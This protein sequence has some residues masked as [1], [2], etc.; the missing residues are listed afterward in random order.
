[1]K[2]GM[3]IYR[4]CIVLTALVL[5]VT[6]TTTGLAQEVS[7]P[8][9]FAAVIQDRADGRGASR[10]QPT[11]EQPKKVAL[12]VGVD[13]YK[14]NLSDLNFAEADVVAVGNELENL[15]FRVQYLTGTKATKQNIE[16]TINALIR[17]LGK[18]DIFLVML[19]GHGQQLR[20]TD[21]DTGRTRDENYF[22]P[23]DAVANSPDDLYSL[24]F[25]VDK[26][27]KENVGTRLVIVDAC[28]NIA[29]ITRGVQGRMITLP[30]DTAI[31]FSCRAGQVSYELRRLKH[32]L[33]THALL[34][35]LRGGAVRNEQISWSQIIAYVDWLMASPEI[36]ELMPPGSAQIPISASNIPQVVLADGMT[37]EP[38]PDQPEGKPAKGPV[39]TNFV[40]NSIGMRLVRVPAG[41][42][43]MGSPL[44]EVDR[45]ADE[46]QH[47]VS[48]EEPFLMGVFEVTQAEFLEVMQTNANPSYFRLRGVGAKAVKRE[49]TDQL[50]VEQVS[51]ADADKFCRLLSEREAEKLAG[52]RYR[53]PREA[54]W[55]YACRAGTSTPFHFGA[56]FTKTQ[57]NADL[58]GGTAFLGHTVDV[59]SYLPNG[60]GLFNMHGNVSEWCD[61]FYAPDFYAQSASVNPVGPPTGEQRVI[62]GG[63]WYDIPMMLRS[64]D[65][66]QADPNSRQPFIGFRVVCDEVKK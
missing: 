3:A 42:F 49:V 40:T 59:A 11:S 8:K 65:R 63:S 15:G 64:A 24:S 47:S 22:C 53:L 38:E 21:R 36:R 41:S 30:E 31:M 28:R 46:L 44:S 18:R 43:I 19:A 58:S 2:W 32:G 1:M 5:L 20:I 34:R 57:A 60:F 12:M 48:F 7:S 55:E 23:Y 56:A 61:D 35:A 6:E 29:E 45:D 17:P 37:S 4:F 66:Q 39:F 33:F 13:V 14:K 62:R 52:R 51:W 26:Q 9:Q 50:P 27:L 25:L 54:E 16:S 10:I